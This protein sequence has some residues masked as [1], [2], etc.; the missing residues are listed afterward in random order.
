MLL[1][2]HVG[3]TLGAAG[4]L[5]RAFAPK[6]DSVSA[7]SEDTQS[8]TDTP[9]SLHWTKRIDWRLVIIGS[10]LPDIIDKPIG[11]LIFADTFNNGRIFAH[12][13]LFAIL[14]LAVGLYFHR[15]GKIGMLVL[16]LCSIGHLILDSMWRMTTTLFWP[17]KGWD[18]P[19]YEI[20]EYWF[21]DLYESISEH[22]DVLIPEIIGTIIIFSVAVYLIK[23]KRVLSFI[24]T[25]KIAE[26]PS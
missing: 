8:A 4:L 12:T 25:G 5:T 3:L 13:L 16:A 26:N 17:L 10:M 1:F 23:N 20:S 6:D 22:I 15:R 2:A 24:R 18:F 9:S 14:L 11:T 7:S 19:E 21:L